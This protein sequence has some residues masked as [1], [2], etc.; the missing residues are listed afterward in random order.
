MWKHPLTESITMTKS[1]TN[2]NHT[3][4]ISIKEA[5]LG[6]AKRGIP[7]FPCIESGEKAKAPYIQGGF[8]NATADHLQVRMHWNKYPN[9]AIGMPTGE[10]SGIFCIDL[11]VDEGKGKN[12]IG[13]WEKLCKEHNFEPYNTKV[14][15]TPRGGRHL[16]FKHQKGLK[17][18]TD[19]ISKGIDTR[20]DGGYIIL[21]TS[22]INGKAYKELND[23]PLAEVPDC[24]LNLLITKEQ[25]KSVTAS[26][27]SFSATTEEKDIVDALNCISPDC[28]YQPWLDLG[29]ALHSWNNSLGLPIWDNWSE[30]S[31]KYKSGACAEKWKSFKGSGITI[32]TLFEMAKKGGYRQQSKKT[33][34]YQQAQQSVPKP[35]QPE[36]WEK[37]LPFRNSTHIGDDSFPLDILPIPLQNMADGLIRTMN[38][39]SS[40][41][42]SLMLSVVS[43]A[44]RKKFKVFIKD[45]HI[46]YGNLD[47]MLVVPVAGSKTPAIKAC[48]PAFLEKQ[49][50]YAELYQ[51]ELHNFYAVE[52]AY[53]H[54]ITK[55]EKSKDDIEAKTRKII[56][57]RKRIGERPTE[58]SLLCSNTS[59]EALERKLF[60]NNEAIGIIC[61]E[62]RTV[63]EIIKGKY[64]STGGTD[65]G[66]WLSG[67][68]GDYIKIDRIGRKSFELFHPILAA[69]LAL[70][71]D[72][73]EAAG[74]CPGLRHSGFL[75]RWLY[76]YCD[77]RHSDYPS[78]NISLSIKDSFNG[79]LKKIINLSD[80]IE[81]D[82]KL[83]SEAF[84]LWK[85]YHDQL[86]RVILADQLTISP[87]LIDCLNKLPEHIAR[88][89]LILH[90]ADTIS[91]NVDSYTIEADT[92][93]DAIIAGDY[94][95][96]HIEK[97]VST[98]GE[99]ENIVLAR[100]LWQWLQS[101]RQW[102]KAQREKEGLGLIEAVKSKDIQ[103][104]E[105]CGLKGI[106]KLKPVI[107]ILVQ[108]GYLKHTEKA[109]KDNPKKHSI[110][111][112]IPEEVI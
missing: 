60:E 92:M 104:Q 98:I 43:I 91:N 63:L 2:N 20:G 75:P 18:T 49:K 15:E 99:N 29:M 1:I 26:N 80:D 90:V 112:L 107:E 103:Q 54:E 25:A 74:E 110:Y 109:I 68:A 105:V 89:A 56:D 53:N 7:I 73:L 58:K 51:E 35:E 71:P 9:A 87:M 69:L 84:S 36:A 46:Q 86:K 42:G 101:K 13:E 61:S 88:L 67:H 55:I 83:S 38:L 3:Q 95:R 5:A 14:I 96:K 76:V 65:C 102:L 50:E 85:Q 57:L 31:S 28:A 97:A 32:A 94:F 12:G 48:M 44:L 37:P 40:M 39:P 6:Y 111:M 66:V 23:L 108:Y 79:L 52:K 30:G 82:V 27:P 11:D 33:E 72:A 70:Q 77:V 45:D 16:Y 34:Y 93:R 106:D 8:K 81:R 64:N 24:I 59:S 10:P 17:I 22:T 41:A 19:N 21:P 62:G 78:E 4:T 47:V 100:K